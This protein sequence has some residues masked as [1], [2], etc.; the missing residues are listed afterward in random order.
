MNVKYSHL[1]A[2]NM[3]STSYTFFLICNAENFVNRFND[4]DVSHN[5]FN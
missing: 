2:T 1:Y 3:E 5:Y 4:D